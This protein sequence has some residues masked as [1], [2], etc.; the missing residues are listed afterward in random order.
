MLGVTLDLGE[1]QAW[2][3]GRPGLVGVIRMGEYHILRRVLQ[4]ATLV[5]ISI[6]AVTTGLGMSVVL[7]WLRRNGYV[8][9]F[10]FHVALYVVMFCTVFTAQV[11][12]CARDRFRRLASSP[13]GNGTSPSHT[14]QSARLGGSSAGDG[15]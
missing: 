8:P 13:T 6:H 5:L 12:L 14:T 15:C 7:V 4:F 1:S 11:D 9:G 3:A 10:V 2:S